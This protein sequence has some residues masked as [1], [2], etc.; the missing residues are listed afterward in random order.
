MH[1]TYFISHFP[2][3]IDTKKTKHGFKIGLLPKFSSAFPAP[4]PP[5]FWSL[6]FSF[7]LQNETSGI[8]L[9]ENLERVPLW[10]MEQG[11]RITK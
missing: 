7:C 6:N 10:W 11:G 8:L 1:F 5:E 2:I 4:P 3:V 9:G